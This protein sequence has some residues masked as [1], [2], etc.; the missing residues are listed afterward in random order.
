MRKICAEGVVSF[1]FA[2]MDLGVERGWSVAGVGKQN[3]MHQIGAEGV[4]SFCFSDIV[5]ERR[6]VLGDGN[7]RARPKFG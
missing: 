4:V 7:R 6:G 3:E 2:D 1:C 5:R